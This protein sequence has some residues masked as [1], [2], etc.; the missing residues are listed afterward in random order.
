[1]SAKDILRETEELNMAGRLEKPFTND[2]L[3]ETVKDALS[4]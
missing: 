3:L 4:G 1:M 2:D